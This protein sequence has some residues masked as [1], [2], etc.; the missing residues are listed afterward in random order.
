MANKIFRDIGSD[1][2]KYVEA[3]IKAAIKTYQV[4]ENLY[5]EEND[6]DKSIKRNTV[7]RVTSK[8]QKIFSDN[9]I[10]GKDFVEKEYDKL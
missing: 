10:D 5:K 2:F 4:E 3:S 1:Y 6:D 7:R 9:K 8:Y